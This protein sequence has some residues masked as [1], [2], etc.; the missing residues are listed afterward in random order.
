MKS[1]Y[2]HA[3][4]PELKLIMRDLNF[5]FY[6]MKLCETEKSNLKL[7]LHSTKVPA[8]DKLKTQTLHARSQV[9]DS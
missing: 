7:Q 5:Q 6:E 3:T 4:N 8:S 9:S 2:T 1:D